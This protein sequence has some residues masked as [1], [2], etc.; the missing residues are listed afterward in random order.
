MSQPPS[1]TFSG[2]SLVTSTCASQPTPARGASILTAPMLVALRSSRLPL[3][4]A[5]VAPHSIVRRVYG[6]GPCEPP[7]SVPAPG[8]TGST[9]ASPRAAASERT[10]IVPVEPAARTFNPDSQ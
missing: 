2:P 7:L 10:S 1:V 3:G 4:S 5:G 8:L 9:G 6:I